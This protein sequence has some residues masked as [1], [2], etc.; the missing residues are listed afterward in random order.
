MLTRRGAS[1]QGGGLQP[2]MG[3]EMAKEAAGMRWSCLG[4]GKQ[5]RCG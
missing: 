5:G 4:P 3:Q 2:G 1:E